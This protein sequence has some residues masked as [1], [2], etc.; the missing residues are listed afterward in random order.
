MAGSDGQVFGRSEGPEGFLGV[1]DGWTNGPSRYPPQ[2]IPMY[3]P[4]PIGLPGYHDQAARALGDYQPQLS[5]RFPAPAVP[6]LALWGSM[7]PPSTIPHYFQRPGVD[8]L[9]YP[10]RAPL[11]PSGGPGLALEGSMG[12]PSGNPHYYQQPGQEFEG[13]PPRNSAPLP[14]SGGPGF[15]LGESTAPPNGTPQYQL[16]WYPAPV[17]SPW[18]SHGAPDLAHGESV[19]Q[20]MNSDLDTEYMFSDFPPPS[21]GDGLWPEPDGTGPNLPDEQAAFRAHFAE[22]DAIDLPGRQRA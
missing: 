22:L 15:V 20:P 3:A 2:T 4:S 21:T 6:N 17:N 1:A 11:P 9:G 16:G 13:Y 5:G 19:A 10:H 14:P 18:S 12:W 7:A 8:F